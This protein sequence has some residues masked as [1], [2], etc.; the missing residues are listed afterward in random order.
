LEPFKVLLPRRIRS[1]ILKEKGLLAITSQGEIMIP[2]ESVV[3]VFFGIVNEE[4]G[5]SEINKSGIRKMLRKVFLGEEHDQQQPQKTF[6]QVH[7]MDIFVKG[8]ERGYRIHGSHFNYPSVLDNVEYISENNFRR[9]MAGI[10][11]YCSCCFFNRSAQ[12]FLLRDKDNVKFYASVYDFE[13][14]CLQSR[15]RMDDQLPWEK[16]KLDEKIGDLPSIKHE[17]ESVKGFSEAEGNDVPQ[18]NN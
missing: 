10:L 3:F 6:R 14:E 4:V 15:R 17:D 5:F 1:A 8:E 2:W 11:K 12:S 18:K 7:L 16:L 9:L 13:L